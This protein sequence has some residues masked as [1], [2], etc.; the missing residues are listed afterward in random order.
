MRPDRVSNPEPLIYAS[1][2][3]PTALR[4]PAKKIILEFSTKSHLNIGITELDVIRA[5]IKLGVSTIL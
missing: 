3:L 1:G 2:A 4:G 5:L